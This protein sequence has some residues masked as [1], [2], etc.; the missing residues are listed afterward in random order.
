LASGRAGAVVGGVEVGDDG[1]V[2]VGDDGGVEVG[3]DGGVE[4]GDD[5]G[6][7]VGDDGP[8]ER[9]G[10]AVARFVGV[11][12][13]GTSVV[14]VLVAP[15]ADGR[16]EAVVGDVTVL[17]ECAPG[18]FNPFVAP[19]PPELDSITATTAATPHKATPTPAA[20]RRRFPWGNTPGRSG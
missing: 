10:V 9:L 2:E 19:L 3:D 12:V 1:G 13:T 14:P 11:F 6:V 4:V 17:A 7:E 20:A 5:G 16:T 18:F 15:A 8:W